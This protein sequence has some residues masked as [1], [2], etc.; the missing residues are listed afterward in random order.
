MIQIQ[1]IIMELKIYKS[2]LKALN[3][4]LQFF[5]CFMMMFKG[6]K[7]WYSC[8]QLCEGSFFLCP[9]GLQKNKFIDEMNEMLNLD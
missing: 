2:M 1:F 4:E 8:N 3:C 7:K 9:H 5:L 6:E